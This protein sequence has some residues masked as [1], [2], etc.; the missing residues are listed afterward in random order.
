MLEPATKLQATVELQDRSIAWQTKQNEVEFE[1]MRSRSSDLAAVAVFQRAHSD[2]STPLVSWLL[3]TLRIRPKWRS[4]HPNSHS[5]A[6]LLL[7]SR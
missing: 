1:E 6:R 7:L 3:T 2:S 5:V 4:L